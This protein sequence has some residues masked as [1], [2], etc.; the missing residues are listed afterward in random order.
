MSKQRGFEGLASLVLLVNVLGDKPSHLNLDKH[1]N[2]TVITGE[3]CTKSAASLER[4]L[5]GEIINIVN[6][7]NLSNMLEEIWN[8]IG[9]IKELNSFMVLVSFVSKE[10]RNSALDI[11]LAPISSMF[12]EIR[13]LNFS[14]WI[15]SRKVWLECNGLPPHAWSTPNLRKIGENWGGVSR[16]NEKTSKKQSFSSVRI[17]IETCIRFFI[18]ECVFLSIGDMSCDVYVKEIFYGNPQCNDST[19][20]NAVSEGFVWFLN[21]GHVEKGSG[22]KLKG[23]CEMESVQPVH[24]NN[25]GS[26]DSQDRCM[27]GSGDN[28]IGYSD[29]NLAMYTKNQ[30]EDKSFNVGNDETRMVTYVDDT[31]SEE[32]FANLGIKALSSP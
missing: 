8:G 30:F 12:F 24:A 16:F 27:E 5:M 21:S 29:I 22:K 7:S 9:D 4:K 32:M 19:R 13:P 11:G 10:A 23:H 6:F 25:Q 17:L 1:D 14:D 15:F 31:R 26:L 3:V 20:G 28:N 2:E 18:K